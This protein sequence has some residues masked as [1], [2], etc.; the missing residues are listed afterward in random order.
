MLDPCTP[1][2]STQVKADRE[3]QDMSVEDMQ[4]IAEEVFEPHKNSS[5][6]EGG[7]TQ[8]EPYAGSDKR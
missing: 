8:A 1:A 6:S 3:A 4:E 5:D 2:A 7:A